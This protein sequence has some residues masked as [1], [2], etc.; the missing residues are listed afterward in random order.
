MCMAGGGGKPQA[1]ATSGQVSGVRDQQGLQGGKVRAPSETPPPPVWMPDLGVDLSSI[2]VEESPLEIDPEKLGPK[3]LTPYIGQLDSVMVGGP[4]P[5]GD[6]YAA[7]PAPTSDAGSGLAAPNP[8][9]NDPNPQ[10]TAAQRLKRISK[11]RLGLAKTV[12]TSS[13]GVTN[14]P[15]VSTPSLYSPGTN[16][17]LGQ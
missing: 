14:S 4:P 2:P 7:P 8:T 1:A 12:L 9:T 16:S 17:K 10:E 13:Q 5:T 6:P 15:L 3:P 11:L